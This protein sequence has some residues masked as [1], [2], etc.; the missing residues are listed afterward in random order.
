MTDDVIPMFELALDG[1]DVK[2]VEE[3]HYKSFSRRLRWRRT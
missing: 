3:K 1:E 2:L